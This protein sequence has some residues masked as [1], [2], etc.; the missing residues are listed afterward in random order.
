[1]QEKLAPSSYTTSSFHRARWNVLD[2]ITVFAGRTIPASIF[3][4]IDM[5]AAEHLRQRLSNDEQKITITAVILKAIAIGQKSHPTSRS[6]RLG[7][8]KL[9]TTPKP[10]AGF[11][12]ERMLSKSNE[13]SQ[14]GD[15]AAVFF[16]VIDDTQ[17]KPLRQIAAELAAYGNGDYKQV[18]QLA[19]E[20]FLS[21]FPWISRQIYVA[22]GLNI[23]YLRT[24]IN[25]ATFG[26]T[27]LGKYGATT[28]IAPN[29]C[30]SIFGVGTVEPQ[31]V[32]ID[33]KIEIRKT[34][35]L[36]YS[37]D[38]LLVDIG[39]AAHFVSTIRDLLESGLAGH[40]HQSDAVETVRI[41]P[42]VSS[43]PEIKKAA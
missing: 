10:V 40:L 15:Q 21:N 39:S 41:I 11:T 16:G 25:R 24:I 23:P 34:M 2:L 9:I 31:P 8:G 37:F 28:I 35:T 17:T 12:V 7:L 19:K 43:E 42:T 38:S 33:D 13:F 36:C 5:E 30:T 26:V 4:D 20:H 1:M 3:C 14:S 27:S 22:M 18:P 29:V 6:Y 32:V